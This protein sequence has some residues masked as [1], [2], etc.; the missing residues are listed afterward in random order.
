MTGKQFERIVDQINP[1]PL[2]ALSFDPQGL[3]LVASNNMRLLDHN[4]PCAFRTLA[5]SQQPHG[6][7]GAVG[8]YAPMHA[9][10]GL[11]RMS[12]WDECG[13]RFSYP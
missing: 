4:A 7:S 6:R 13:G 5:V 10:P 1:L 3:H 12:R 8:G 11:G 9:L 2:L